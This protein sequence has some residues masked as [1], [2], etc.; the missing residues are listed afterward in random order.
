MFSVNYKC[1]Y[2]IFHFPRIQLIFRE[3]IKDALNVI[4]FQNLHAKE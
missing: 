1:S 4:G 3:E 2:L